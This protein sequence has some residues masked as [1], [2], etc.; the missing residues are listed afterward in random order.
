MI[1][2]SLF[3]LLTVLWT[4]R[5]LVAALVLQAQTS[6]SPN[7]DL[8]IG[9]RPS[10]LAI[11]QAEA[12][13]YALKSNN[14][15]A[16]IVIQGIQA[17]GDY[18]TDENSPVETKK[19]I[20][21]AVASVDFT[22]TL[23]EAVLNGQVDMAVHSLKDIPPT[24]RWREGLTIACHLP[25]ED[26]LDVLISRQSNGQP[27]TINSLPQNAKV[28][29]SSVRRQAQLLALR[30]DFE[31][32]NVR[33]NIETRLR[34]LTEDPPTVD[35]LVLAQ[36]GLNRLNRQKQIKD[37]DV[38]SLCISPISPEEMLPGACQGIVAVVCRSGDSSTISLLQKINNR[39][40]SI[41]AAAERSFLDALDSFSPENYQGTIPWKGRPPLAAF[42]EK[43]T[44]KHDSKE[45]WQFRGLLAHPN[46]TR[47]IRICE[48][49]TTSCRKGF[50]I[51]EAR[52]LG[53]NCAQKLLEEAG[54]E[55]YR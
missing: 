40:S 17:K 1:R 15:N 5:I 31:L 45:V 47:V 7:K 53:N 30:P 44:H 29:T 8:I 52:N 12:I 51:E 22:S 55:F 2:S 6:T 43:Q 16:E 23:D 4:R 3:I 13:S 50:T 20:P 35:I 19:N 18:T 41:A 24:H 9:T 21:L 37:I 28:G 36:A 26:P 25:R 54:S 11:A 34:A 32:V 39:N 33:G 38:S 42:M 48:T 49:I 46:G 14:S 10:P 27:P